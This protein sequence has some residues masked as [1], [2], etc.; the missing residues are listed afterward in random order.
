MSSGLSLHIDSTYF[1]KLMRVFRM[2]MVLF[3]VLS[4]SILI[5][6]PAQASERSRDASR[7]KN[8]AI[9]LR[10][11][12]LLQKHRRERPEADGIIGI[13]I[14]KEDEARVQ[15]YKRSTSNG[16]RFY[17]KIIWLKKPL[18]DGKLQMDRNNPDPSK[19]G[20]LLVGMTILRDFIFRGKGKYEDGIIYDPQTGKD[21]DCMMEL[22]ER[23][24]LKVRGFIG[25]RVLG[26][27]EMFRRATN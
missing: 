15:I 19:R 1:C 7:K 25:L 24:K 17:G 16:E 3:V 8:A 6:Q 26:R 23:N 11:R 12:L 5:D 4:G 20:T 22:E 27:T 2:C 21:Y 10:S 14:A 18:K 13:W 9:K